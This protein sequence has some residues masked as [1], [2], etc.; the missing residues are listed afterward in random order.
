MLQTNLPMNEGVFEPLTVT[1]PPGSLLDPYPP[2]AV[3]AGNVETSQRITDV[4]FGAL[5][6]ALPHIIPAASQG[7]MNNVT[8]GGVLAAKSEERISTRHSPLATRHSPL[9]TRH[10]PFVYYE[11]LGGGIGAGP[12]A[13]GGH[14]MHSHMS[15]TRNTPVEALEYNFPLRIREYS[16]RHGSGGAGKYRGGDGLVRTIEFLT[17]VTATI[18]SERRERPAYGLNGGQP[19]QPGRNSLIRNGQTNQLPGKIT[20]DLKTG[21]ILR[22]ETPGGGGWG[23]V[24]ET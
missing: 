18:M 21:D 6:Q 7:T 23:E 16:L 15:N 5:A 4:V 19:G 14:G 17:P 9:A 11:T 1:I 2:H 8:F 20:L 13:D 3:A 12:A 24:D 22:V 10:S